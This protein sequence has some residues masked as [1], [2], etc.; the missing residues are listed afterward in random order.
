MK[1]R[2]YVPN[3][4]LNLAYCIIAK[5]IFFEVK[6]VIS[7]EQRAHEIAIALMAK[8][9]DPKQPI[10]AYHDYINYLL[11]ILKEIDKDFP[12]GIKEHLE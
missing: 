4:K 8:T 10:E 12:M 1:S 2:A 7:N 5:E 9:A 3:A 6:T 11:P